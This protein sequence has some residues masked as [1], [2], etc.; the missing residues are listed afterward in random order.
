MDKIIYHSQND[1][2]ILIHTLQ[3]I[4]NAFGSKLI[5]SKSINLYI[6]L[7]KEK[8]VDVDLFKST[9]KILLKIEV[10]MNV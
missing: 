8:D 1:M 9:K 10:S 2:R 4:Y 3:D 6:E 7:S 5:N